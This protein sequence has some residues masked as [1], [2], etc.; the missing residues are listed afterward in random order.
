MQA[1][2]PKIKVDEDRIFIEDRN[3]DSEAWL[4]F[5]NGWRALLPGKIRLKGPPRLRKALGP[6][7][8]SDRGAPSRGL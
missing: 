3:V 4:R 6:A 8:P 1:R 5:L 7:S 2:Y